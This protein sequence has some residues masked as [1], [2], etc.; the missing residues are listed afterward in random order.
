MKQYKKDRL[1]KLIVWGYITQS[2]A[3]QMYRDYLRGIIPT[4][5]PKLLSA[6]ITV[7]ADR[8]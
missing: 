8:K 6:F 2:Q 1:R 5:Q 7:P 3:N 4:E